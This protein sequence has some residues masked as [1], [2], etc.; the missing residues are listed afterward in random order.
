[1]KCGWLDVTNPNH[2]SF[3]RQVLTSQT[4]ALLVLHRN[5]AKIKERC[6]FV[7]M[8][9][10]SW[11]DL[12]SHNSLATPVS[13]LT[14]TEIDEVNGGVAPI[15]IVLSGVAVGLSIAYCTRNRG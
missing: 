9:E 4:V 5:A 10:M 1:M 15:V 6:M 13:G 2:P 14:G 11:S 3:Y 7:H 12:E 8:H